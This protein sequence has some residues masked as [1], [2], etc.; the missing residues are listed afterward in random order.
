MN[1]DGDRKIMGKETKRDESDVTCIILDRYVVNEV[2]NRFLFGK[3]KEWVLYYL[4]NILTSSEIPLI[5]NKDGYEIIGFTKKDEEMFFPPMKPRSDMYG[6]EIN[7]YKVEGKK[8]IAGLREG[9]NINYLF[10]D[11]DTLIRIYPKFSAGAGLD[12]RFLSRTKNNL[13]EKIIKN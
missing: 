5:H 12:A 9:D 8:F 4:F 1:G 10:S 13:S 3:K 7:V 6:G 11:I 2:R